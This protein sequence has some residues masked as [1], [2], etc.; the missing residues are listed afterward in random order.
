MRDISRKTPHLAACPRSEPSAGDM[1]RRAVPD[2]PHKRPAIRPVFTAGRGG[3]PSGL[4]VGLPWCLQSEEGKRGE[5]AR[6]TKSAAHDT[7]KADDRG[8]RG[9]AN[10]EPVHGKIGRGAG[11]FVC[12]AGGADCRPA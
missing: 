7:A 11:N 9:P 12:E 8:P 10:A 3:T 4:G 2:P 5:R 1:L 6:G